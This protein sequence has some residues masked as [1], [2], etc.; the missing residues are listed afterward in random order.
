VTA[1]IATYA[2]HRLRR[3]EVTAPAS[4]ASEHDT[5]DAAHA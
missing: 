1:G 5:L 4:A 3:A 2:A